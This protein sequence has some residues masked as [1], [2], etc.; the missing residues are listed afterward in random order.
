VSRADE[1][2]TCGGYPHHIPL[3]HACATARKNSAPARGDLQTPPDSPSEFGQQGMI[4]ARTPGPQLGVIGPERRIRLATRNSEDAV[5]RPSCRPRGEEDADWWK[6][7][8]L[9]KPEGELINTLQNF[10][11]L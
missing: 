9:Y 8:T 6:P 11:P 4:D 1:P 2:D 3:C 7:G 10:L 5:F